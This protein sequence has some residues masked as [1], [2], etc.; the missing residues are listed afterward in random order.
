MLEH[1]C[2]Y[3]SR[4]AWWLCWFK[5]FILKW[6]IRRGEGITVWAEEIY[7]LPS[8]VT[9]Q[10]QEA[11]WDLPFEMGL[12]LATE[13][14]RVIHNAL[15]QLEI[16]SSLIMNSVLHPV[17]LHK[18]IVL[19]FRTQLWTAWARSLERLSLSLSGTLEIG[20]AFSRKTECSLAE[21]S[22]PLNMP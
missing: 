13:L 16:G 8:P 4:R 10:R 11:A 21:K 5:Y 6:P 9:W 20:Y 18:T 19:P 3:S 2:S 1:G 17:Q 14:L 12:R 22:D 15:F 7:N